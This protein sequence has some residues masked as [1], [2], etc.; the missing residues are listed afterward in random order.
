MSV[1]LV[2][3]AFSHLLTAENLA[4]TNS[5]DIDLFIYSMS[6]S[7]SHYTSS[8]FIDIIINT[9]VLRK[10]TADYRQFQV[11]QETDPTL[12]LNI[13]IKR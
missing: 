1:E 7:R 2:N 3:R 5:S 9:G 4:E 12:E 6:T 8:I 13:L 10:S 11:L